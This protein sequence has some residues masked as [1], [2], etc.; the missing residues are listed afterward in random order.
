MDDPQDDPASISRV[1]ETYLMKSW[2]DFSI[3][4]V[5]LIVNE[6]W[7]KSFLEK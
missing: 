2:P 1:A 4:L 7:N 3:V 5:F 6:W